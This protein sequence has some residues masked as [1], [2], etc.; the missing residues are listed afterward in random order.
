MR[1]T[2]IL[3]LLFCSVLQAQQEVLVL[4]KTNGFRHSSIEKGVQTFKEIGAKHNWNITHSEDSLVFTKKNL[5]KIDLVIFLNTTGDIFGE[6]QEKAFKN[7]MENGGR[8]FGIHAAS[9]T[10]FEWEWFGKFIGG[11]FKSHPNK[12]TATIHKT[13]AHETV[14]A[15]PETMQRFDE[16]YNFY[17]LNPDVTVTL[18]LDESSYEGGENGENHPYAWFQEVGDGL[19]YYTG[20][21]HTEESYD[22]PGFRQHLEDVM[23]WLLK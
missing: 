20:G 3:A 23:L 17:N 16:W 4:T 10:E 7:Y 1:F 13:T 11:Y 22:E 5:D 8:F 14:K 15:F 2:L 6:S 19:M 9:D 18:S 12:Q 21:G